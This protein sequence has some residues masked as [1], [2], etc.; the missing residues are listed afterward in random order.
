MEGQGAKSDWIY[1][2]LGWMKLAI[3]YV[4]YY[5]IDPKILKFKMATLIR[6]PKIRKVNGFF[7]KLATRG[8]SR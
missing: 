5:E 1:M 2:K 7:M 6:R 3:F 4:D 8:F